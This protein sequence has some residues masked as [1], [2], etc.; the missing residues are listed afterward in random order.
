MARQ[1]TDV[2]LT[3]MESY[4]PGGWGIAWRGGGSGGRIEGSIQIPKGL[5]ETAG[6]NILPA[7][8]SQVD[9][10]VT[11]PD[12]KNV[13]FRSD[14]DSGWEGVEL[15]MA[16]AAQAGFDV[17]LRGSKTVTA[18]VGNQVRDLSFPVTLGPDEA[19]L[20]RRDLGRVFAETPADLVIFW[21]DPGSQPTALDEKQE[22]LRRK[23]KAIG[24]I[25]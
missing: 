11:S 4:Y 21:V 17:D 2:L 18:Q 22:E 14:L 7:V 10:L 19:R 8:D 23:L 20:G 9:A 24:Y 5:I 3:A 6:H 15:R 1:M 13:G 16:G 25:D 12:R